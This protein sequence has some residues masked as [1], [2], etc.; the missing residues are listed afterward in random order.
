MKLFKI[1]AVVGGI[2]V[3]IK[4]CIVAKLYHS[5]KAYE[6]GGINTM[7]KVLL[8]LLILSIAGKL[9]RGFKMK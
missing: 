5:I 6:A 7:L 1:I 8:C 3:L 4:L 2:F 9:F